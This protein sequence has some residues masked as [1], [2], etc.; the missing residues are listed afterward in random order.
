MA[1]FDAAKIDQ[2]AAERE[3]LEALEAED[4]FAGLVPVEA[5]IG[6]NLTDLVTFRMRSE[7]FQEIDRAAS[8]E[9]MSLS[10]FIRRS[11]LTRAREAE[12]LPSL[13]PSLVDTLDQLTKQY[14]DLR[15]KPRGSRARSKANAT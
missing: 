15:R 14:Q 13:T 9:G 12:G 8:R 6:K 4:P 7:E 2:D 10:E 11:A 3:M 5:K 1:T